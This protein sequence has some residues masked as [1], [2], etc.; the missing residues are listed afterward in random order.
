ML[1]KHIGKPGTPERENFENELRLDLLEEEI[2]IKGEDE[3]EQ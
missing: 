2:K 3:T 1:D